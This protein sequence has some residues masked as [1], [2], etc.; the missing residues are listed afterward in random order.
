MKLLP[1]LF[2]DIIKIQLHRKMSPIHL[3]AVGIWR[4]IT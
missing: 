4:A 3:I 1:K 2:S